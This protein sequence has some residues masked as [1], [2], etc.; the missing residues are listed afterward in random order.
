M[1]YLSYFENQDQAM[2]YDGQLGAP[3]VAYVE[4]GEQLLFAPYT[5][6]VEEVKFKF[7]NGQLTL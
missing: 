3:H 1:K 6:G 4:G 7:E 2:S 5:E